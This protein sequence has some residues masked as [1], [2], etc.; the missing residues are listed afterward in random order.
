MQLPTFNSS[1][2][3]FT[4]DVGNERK[5]LAADENVTEEYLV[6][7]KATVHSQTVTSPEYRD[8]FSKLMRSYRHLQVTYM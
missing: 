4:E 2:I 1:Y 3:I 7:S 8:I 5:D 6:Q